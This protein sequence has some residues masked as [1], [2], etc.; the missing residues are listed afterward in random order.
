[1]FAA[2]VH[3]YIWAYFHQ[4]ATG[5]SGMGGLAAWLVAEEPDVDTGPAPVHHVSAARTSHR[6][7]VTRESVSL[8]QWLHLKLYSQQGIFLKLYDLEQTAG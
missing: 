5:V 2:S 1:M 3:F 7:G 4:M 8:Q 6:H